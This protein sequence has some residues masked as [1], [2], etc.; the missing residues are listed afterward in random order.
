MSQNHEVAHT[1]SSLFAAA[2]VGF[3]IN[4]VL[5]SALD[6]SKQRERDVQIQNE[7]LRDQLT[8]E[9]SVHELVLRAEDHTFGFREENETCTGNYEVRNNMA[10]VVGPLVCT[11][12]VP[13]PGHS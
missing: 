11:H 3:M 2:I 1:V 4:S 7:Q 6:D 10:T 9:H 13:L 8:P 12:T 5:S